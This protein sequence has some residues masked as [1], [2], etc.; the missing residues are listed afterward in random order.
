MKD[1][2]RATWCVPQHREKSLQCNPFN[3]THFETQ[4]RWLG[5]DAESSLHP[6]PGCRQLLPQQLRGDPDL[7]ILRRV[8]NSHLSIVNDH[9]NLSPVK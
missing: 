7:K 6:C 8:V 4:N 3:S 2:P 9:T 5:A 1:T